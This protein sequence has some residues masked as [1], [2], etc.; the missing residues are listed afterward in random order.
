M[1]RVL[2]GVAAAVLAVGG[3]ACANPS[4]DSGNQ[5]PPAAPAQTS[6]TTVPDGGVGD[7]VHEIGRGIA[8][9]QWET[10]APAGSPG[11][12]WARLRNAAGGPDA[13]ITNGLVPAGAPGIVQ[14]L[15]TDR[16]VEFSGGCRWKPAA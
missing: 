11:C 16:F 5:P 3:W 15:P 10:V 4:S 6:A 14:V 13:I 7:G 8:A 2:A 1:K 9:G 12:Y